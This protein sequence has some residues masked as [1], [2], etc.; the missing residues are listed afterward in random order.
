MMYGDVPGRQYS[1]W[2]LDSRLDLPQNCT[3]KAKLH[4]QV[5]PVDLQHC[6]ICIPVRQQQDNDN[7]RVFV[8]DTAGGIDVPQVADYLCH[9]STAKLVHDDIW[10]KVS[11]QY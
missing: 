6:C 7:K 2:T 5:V 8:I 10:R 9:S 1:H 4:S 11:V 3:G